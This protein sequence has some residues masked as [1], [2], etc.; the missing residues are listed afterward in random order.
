MS[1]FKEQTNVICGKGTLFAGTYKITPPP[2]GVEIGKYCAIANNIKIMGVNH[3][4][5]FPSIQ[6]TFYKKFFDSP[7]PID[8]S[9]NVRTKGKI[10]IGNDVWIGEDVFILSGVTIGDGCCIGARSVVTKSLPPYSICVGTPCYDV[11]KRYSDEMITFLTDLKWWDWDDEKIK[12]N[13]EFFMTNLNKK[14][15]DQVKKLIV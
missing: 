3:D 7:Y 13:K 5:N 11:K 12:K 10:T 1:E 2:G 4:Y 8:G 14:T 6:G 15:V 9:S